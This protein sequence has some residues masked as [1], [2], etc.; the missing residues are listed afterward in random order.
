MAALG[1]RDAFAS[2]SIRHAIRTLDRW[3]EAALTAALL[4]DRRRSDAAG[5]LRRGVGGPRRPRAR[6]GNVADR[7]GSGAG[8]AS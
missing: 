8:R 1:D 5:A 7:M 3:D 6:V 4:D 2:W